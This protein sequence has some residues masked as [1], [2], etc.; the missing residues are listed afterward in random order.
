MY[1]LIIVL[2]FVTMLLLP[3]GAKAQEN[4]GQNLPVVRCASLMCTDPYNRALLPYNM[5]L[6]I[7]GGSR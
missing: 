5:F 3:F 4:D 2:V 6:P 7:I 1:K